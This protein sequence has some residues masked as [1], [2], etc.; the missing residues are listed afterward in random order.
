MAGIRSVLQGSRSRS[1][2]NQLSSRKDDA[3]STT[4][5]ILP[6][7]IQSWIPRLQSIRQ[8]ISGFRS[9]PPGAH[10]RCSSAEVSGTQ[11]TPPCYAST[12]SSAGMRRGSSVSDGDTL[13]TVSDVLLDEQPS[14][15]AS[16]PVVPKYRSFEMQSGI[17][18]KCA[19]QGLSLLTS[20]LQE[21]S[22][23]ESSDD[24]TLSLSRQLY[25]H[26]VTYLLRG[27]PS[28]LN[29]EETMFLETSLP[30]HMTHT[31]KLVYV[32]APSGQQVRPYG[33]D[34]TSQS[35]HPPP[36]PSWLHRLL[37]SSIIQL[38]L[39]FRFILPYVKLFIGHAYQYERKHRLSEGLVSW[40]M[41]TVGELGRRGIQFTTTIWQMND[42]K[43][44]H[45]IN[46]FTVWWL[47]GVT[48]GI[49]EGISKGFMILAAKGDD[50]DDDD[51]DLYTPS[52]SAGHRDKER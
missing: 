39:L 13:Q 23:P 21:Y 30:P 52:A 44:G 46:D 9:R 32:G 29:V 35:P 25:L 36:E 27:L 17:N 33:R 1:G 16:T 6:A 38:F 4:F 19:N 34:S 47:R 10:S 3:P 28:N 2:G 11:L 49:H 41:N 43:V 15:S 14:S 24:G 31:T 37:A 12:S 51:D 42:G 50:N 18:L 40:S 20:A 48:G 22:S 7:P 26:A 45:A 8:R 5:T